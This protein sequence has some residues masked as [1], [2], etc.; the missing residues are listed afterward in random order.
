M[1]EGMDHQ[2]RSNISG[3]IYFLF[4]LIQ[5]VAQIAGSHMLNITKS[6]ESFVSEKKSLLK[7]AITPVLC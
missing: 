4:G 7:M 6:C 3:Q 1:T 2:I 5:L